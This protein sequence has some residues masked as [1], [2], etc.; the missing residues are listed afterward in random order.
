ME[1]FDLYK[2]ITALKDG[3]IVV[4][5]TD[6]LYGIGADIFN[7][8]A[9]KK[10]FLIKNRPQNIPLSVAVHNIDAINKL[11]FINKSAKTWLARKGFDAMY[12]ARP[13]SRL[14][15]KKIRQPLSEQILFGKIEENSIVKITCINNELTI[16]T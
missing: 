14:I 2:V 13:L 12:G 9:I 15:Q 16:K 10:V 7:F 8:K 6:T 11:A 3:K 5:P 4:Y 1:N